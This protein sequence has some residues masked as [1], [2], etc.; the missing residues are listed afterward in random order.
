MSGAEERVLDRSVP[1]PA[2]ELT[3]FRFPAFEHHRLP[4]GL[5]VYLA[6]RSPAPLVQID[7]VTAAGAHFDPPGAAG[8]ATLTAAL[9]DEGTEGR[10][11]L[12][13]AGEVERLGGYLGTSAD[14]DATYLSTSLLSHHVVAGLSLLAELATSPSFPTH[15]IERLRRLRLAELRRRLSQPATLA[16]D[17]LARVIYRDTVFASPLSGTRQSVEAISSDDIHGFYRRY[18]G[19]EGSAV[20]A[21]GRLDP[22]LLL[23]HVEAVLGAWDGAPQPQP[24]AI[25]PAPLTG[26]QVEIIDRPNSVQTEL[27]LGHVGVPRGH[28]D[29]VPLQVMNALFG[30]KFTSR[31]NLNLRERHGFTYGAQSRFAA[32]LGPGPFVVSTSVATEFTGRAVEETQ[33]E[34]ARLLEEP[35]SQ[36]EVEDTK[37]YLLGT[38]PYTLQ[39]IDGLARRLEVLAIHS[40]PDDYYDIYLQAIRGV[41]VAQVGQLARRHLHPDRMAIVTVGPAETLEKQLC[42]F[43]PVSVREVGDPA[44]E[45]SP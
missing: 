22:E 43:G 40:L 42:R 14:W 39:R 21:V 11:A 18:F 16:A 5:Q 33:K 27:R 45:A 24:A 12:E 20:I 32:R 7:L 38:F 41:D 25:D 10:S 26:L 8:L 4:N 31:V 2:A 1:P 36:E 23:S 3:P 9:I 29:Y 28:R 30:G 19:P 17:A 34:L 6:R 15:E 13:I 37:N 35:V 44:A